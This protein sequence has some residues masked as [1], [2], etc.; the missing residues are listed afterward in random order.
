MTMGQGDHVWERFGHNA[1]GIRD[2]ALG[3]D[4]IY[5]WGTF[6]FDAPGFVPRFLTGRMRYWV[7]AEDAAR[8]LEAY[9]YWN[10]SIWIQ[11]L[12]L[13][14]AQR[15]A[16]RDFVEWNAREENKFYRY[17]YFGDNCSTRV[18]DAL[19]R[20]L[21]GAL[22]AQFGQAPSGVT[23]RDETRRL[24]A[25][26]FWTFL[27]IDLALGTPSDREMTRW[28]AMYV[29]GAVRDA[30]R[31]VRLRTDNGAQPLVASEQQV[32]AARRAPEPGRA[33]WPFARLLIVGLLI[34][35]ALVVLSAR[36]GRS[37]GRIASF[38]AG[39]WCLVS[40]L[41]GTILVLMWTATEHVWTH[42]NA[43]LLLLSPLWIVAL[44][45][46][47]RARW[48][49]RAAGRLVVWTLAA[50]A[51]AALVVAGLGHPQRSELVVALA[52]PLHVAVLWILVR[53]RTAAA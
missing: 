45:G 34:A 24:T 1:L 19:D 42:A 27:G 4:V 16:A 3:T 33:P 47:R 18:R 13:T 6:S 29:P 8:A 48:W 17:D 30:L 37:G 31:E 11:E 44:W 23:F 51:A 41:V 2:R 49:D 12:R 52:L 15:V 21:G 50:L 20:I 25:G 28:E 39:V 46:I 32:F 26:G 43:N 9:Q 10:R 36:G 5:N 14:P 53:P 22:R 38:L 35:S 7:Q 40:G